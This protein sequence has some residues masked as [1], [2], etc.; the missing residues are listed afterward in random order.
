MNYLTSQLLIKEELK[1][2]NN[3]LKNQN[4]NWEDGKKT[5]G[6]YASKVKNNLQL[7]RNSELSR[8][9]AELIKIKILL[10]FMM[11]IFLIMNLF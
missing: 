6:N 8:K 7:N 3:D 10:M 11:I 5:A 4:N 2:I 9:Y 1:Q